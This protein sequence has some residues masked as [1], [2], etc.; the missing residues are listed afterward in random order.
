MPVLAYHFALAFLSKKEGRKVV[1]GPMV[2][3]L[4]SP[5]KCNRVSVPNVSL[6][7]TDATIAAAASNASSTSVA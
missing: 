3:C 2:A 6:P 1:H 5:Y 7:A 4:Y